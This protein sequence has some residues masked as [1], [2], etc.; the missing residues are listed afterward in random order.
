MFTEILDAEVTFL[1]QPFLPP[2][3]ISSGAITTLTEAV[4][5]VTDSIAGKEATGPLLNL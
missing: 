1:E 4:A 5:Q 2:L 3:I